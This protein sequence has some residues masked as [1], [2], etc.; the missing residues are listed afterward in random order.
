MGK[1]F[2]FGAFIKLVVDQKSLKLSVMIAWTINIAKKFCC[3]SNMPGGI[4]FLA[5]SSQRVYTPCVT[6]SYTIEIT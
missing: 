6:C 3:H 4:Q 5:P 1:S 2:A